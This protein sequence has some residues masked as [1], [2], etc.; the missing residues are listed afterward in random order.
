MPAALAI[1]LITGAVSAGATIYGANKAAGASKD[2][3]GMQQQAAREA[4]ARTQQAQ[5]QAIGYIDQAR[6]APRQ[7]S[8]YSQAGMSSLANLGFNVPQQAQQAPPTMN[9]PMGPPM[10]LAS[11]GSPQSAGM[12]TVRAPNGQTQQRPVAERDHWLQKG[13]QVF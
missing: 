7:S 8:P 11:M 4:A 10:S 2:A 3:A 6:T 9:R 5:Q 1:P 13:A 12:I